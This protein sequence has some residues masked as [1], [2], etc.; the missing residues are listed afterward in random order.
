MKILPVGATI[1]FT[2]KRIEKIVQFVFDR[3]EL[4]AEKQINKNK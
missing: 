3:V 2:R 1:I 4:F